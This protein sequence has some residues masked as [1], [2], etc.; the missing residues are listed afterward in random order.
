MV[1]ACLV[2]KLYNAKLQAKYMI[3]SAIQAKVNKLRAVNEHGYFFQSNRNT[4]KKLSFKAPAAS[5]E[6][7]YLLLQH[8]GRDG[9]VWVATNKS[10]HLCVVKF[11]HSGKKFIFS[12]SENKTVNK[13]ADTLATMSLNGKNS[14]N[15]N[16]NSDLVNKELKVWKK[17]YS[18]L[19]V[20]PFVKI[21]AG[22]DALIIPFAFCFECDGQLSRELTSY[23][24][25]DVLFQMESWPLIQNQLRIHSSNAVS[26]LFDAVVRVA[27]AGYCHKDIKWQHL[28]LL[29][30][31]VSSSSKKSS[32][33][34]PPLLK[35]ILV[36]LS[37]VE[38]TS[39]GLRRMSLEIC[40]SLLNASQRQEFAKLYNDKS[41]LVL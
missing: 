37:D 35:P 39:D 24:P 2:W 10:G 38:E 16:V 41:K 1:M 19:N 36:D 27:E 33:S 25:C 21:L 3:T 30:I 4:I 9:K 14:C 13:I 26:L 31:F 40:S 28:A 8:N 20:Q 18:N 6:C 32:P 17:I 12:M 22:R 7:F 29:P 23:I 34:T 15:N 11:R 5:S